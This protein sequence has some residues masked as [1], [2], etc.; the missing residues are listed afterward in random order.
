MKYFFR[1]VALLGALLT[2]FVMNSANAQNCTI[3]AG[4]DTKVCPGTT[5]VLQGTSS[6]L[7]SVNPKWSQISGP[8]V[9]ITNPSSLNTT[10]TGYSD[11]AVYKFR[12]TATCVDGSL[13]YNDVTYTTY[14]AT[15]ANAGPD[16]NACPG[17]T[18]MAANAVGANETGAWTVVGSANSMTLTNATS[19]TTTVTLPANPGGTTT[20]R[21]TITNGVN[22][23]NS[24]DDII[25]KNSGGT[26]PVTAGS[27]QV[28]SNCY[29]LTQTANLTASYPG[30]TNGQKGV[31]SLVSGPNTPTF[32]N[33]NNSSTTLSNLIQGVYIVRWTVS[34][35]CINGSDDVQITVPAPTQSVSSAGGSTQTFCDSRTSVVLTGG[36]PGYTG[37]TV[38][39]VRTAGTGNISDPTSPTTTITGLTGVSSTFRYT[40]TAPG[41]CVSSANYTVNF[42]TPPTISSSTPLVTPACDVS[43]IAIP[44]TVTGGDKTQ[45]TIVSGPATSTIVTSNTLNSYNDVITASPL[46]LAGFDKVGNYTIR[47]RRTTN[48]GNGG[49]SDAYT[50]VVIVIS[51]TS[52]ASNAGTKQ[53]LA[54]N[55]FNTNLAGNVPLEGIGAWSQVSG[56]NTANITDNTNPTTAINGLINGAY[57][58]RWIV[59]GNVSCSNNQSD[60][61]V[62]VANVAPTAA[63]AGSARTV[64]TSTPVQLAGNVPALN[65]TGTWSVIPATGITFS[66]VNDPFATVS[67]LPGAGTYKFVWKIANSCAQS[68]D[69]L[70][71]TA[72]ATAGPKQANAGPDQCLPAGTTSFT[73]AGNATS[74]GETGAWTIASGPNT[75]S[76]TNSALNNTTVTGA[77]NGTYKLV[78]NL[79]KN[80]CAIT[81][82]TVVITISGAVTT[83]TAGTDQR[84]CGPA[85][86]TL[87]GNVPAIGTGLWTQTQGPGGITFSDPTAN[88]TSVSGLGDGRYVFRWT[89]TNG[90][91]ASSFAE[92]KIESSAAPT[93]ANAG[94]DIS[95]CD[96]T[97]AK[98]A[99]NTI[100]KGIGMWSVI[101]SPGN[102]TFSSITSPTATLSNLKMGTYVLR[103]TSTN[104]PFCPSST[105]DVNI[106][107][108]QKAKVTAATQNLCNVT[109]TTLTGNEGSTGV[110][111]ATSGPATTI[112][113]NSNNSAL[114]TGMV[115]GNVYNFTYTIAATADCAA[116]S[117]VVTVTVSAPPSAANGGPDQS[118]CI[119]DP[120]TT[121]NTTL[122]ATTPAVGTG[123]WTIAAQPSGSTPALGNNLSGTSTFTNL[124]EGTYILEW[125]VSNGYC[126]ANKDIV[127]IATYREP[128]AA[129]A[130]AT[131]PNACSSE[132]TLQGNTP[133]VGLGTWTVD[134]GPN[135]PVIDQPNSPTT[136]VL[137]AITGTYVF[138]W[139]ITNGPTCTPKTSTVTVVVTSTPPTTAQANAGAIPTQI[140]NPLPTISVPLGG[141][142]PAGTEVGTWTVANTTGV[143]PTFTNA[144]NPT[145]NVNGLK[146]GTY[147]LMWTIN[148]GSCVSKDS[149]TLRV[150]DQPAAANA[151]A[152]QQMCLYS[153]V[154]LTATA[155]TAGTGTWSL[156][157]AAP[158]TP[159]F[160][161]INA[162]NAV[163]TGLL[164]GTYPLRFTVSNGVCAVSTSDINIQVEDCRIQIAKTASTPLLNADGSYTVVFKFNVTNPGNI[165]INN[166]QVT[167]NLAPVFPSPKTFTVTSITG[168]GTF[169]GMTNAGFNGK[170]DQNLLMSS[171][172]LAG[173]QTQTITL[174]V[175]VNL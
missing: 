77:V 67:S 24:F 78:W 39:W 3:N 45:W 116:T 151:G 120:A 143:T 49:C 168:T 41:G 105:D 15:L 141:N 96:G 165:S 56:P 81:R 5:F 156:N 2:A 164:P 42:T 11:N 174:Q 99:A 152:S 52:T 71:I 94:N 146:E 162:P 28:L 171:A 68:T 97:T 131:Q 19:P 55:V 148:M 101:T 114:V 153:P 139:T 58:F 22:G 100:T 59:T 98:L 109:T 18:T 76:F 104:S 17:T 65:E 136:K 134:S 106:I 82:D 20:F 72:S 110:W 23:C 51:R 90:A 117:D 38:T 86:Y 54:C 33:I 163:V 142:A 60:V 85:T 108:T 161:N 95:I 8:A 53:V 36:T 159:V 6:G 160:S 102:P 128:S 144:N 130:G 47:L 13:I 88:N 10:V 26:T 135:T 7:I 147:K 92:V 172:T 124:A 48:N 166:V 44:Y 173:G 1:V 61:S 112:S 73:L 119:L 75:P 91:C 125:N 80:G 115:P 83:A 25:V 137:N 127:R 155:P 12:L 57:T 84:L 43:A 40:I 64:C 150:F 74:T 158:S 4:V 175:K 30:N 111:T 9:T 138:R 169:S 32:G 149:V 46:S 14:P 63:A 132:V 79:E 113:A 31:W 170:T 62:V 118:L 21:W 157:G 16:I 93:P 126:T 69:T 154:T 37:E 66:N 133:A 34:G 145:T 103:W 107:V 123:K 167:D 89:I 50:D 140:C 87:N 27:D 129:N 122:A 35:T 29:T 70:V 121:I